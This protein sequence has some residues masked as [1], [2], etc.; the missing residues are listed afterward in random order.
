MPD[1][2]PLLT[3]SALN[4]AIVSLH[5]ITSSGDRLILDR[6]YDNIINNLRMSEINPDPE[7]TELYRE[8]VR[9]IQKGRLRDDIR[10]VIIK[11]DSEKKQKS[12]KEIITGNVLRSFSINPLKWLSKLAMSSASE[13][14]TQ[15]KE[16]QE[17]A[18]E[19]AQNNNE[20]QLRLKHDE[21][22]EYDELQRKLLISSWNLMSHY[23]LSDNY[24]LTQKALAKFSSV[25]NESDPSKRKTMMKYLEGDFSM[26]APYWFYRAKSASESGNDDEAGT[27]FERF[28]E[29]WRPALM[30]DSYQAEAMKY[31]IERLMRSGVNQDNAGEILKCLAVMRANT[32]LDDWAN[33]IFAGMIY[34]ALGMKDEAVDC[35]ICNVL[36]K[37]ENEM[38]SK[39][40]ERI[41]TE[42]FPQRIDLDDALRSAAKCGDR[43]VVEVLIKHGADVNAKSNYGFTALM[44]AAGRGHTEIVDALI[45]SGADVNAKDNDG[46]TA[47]MEAAN[48]KVAEL[49]IK[50]GAD[51]NA[52]ENDGETAL[53]WAYN[54]E[55]AE[56]LIKHGAD[57]NAKS[58]YGRT[59]LMI[60]TQEGHKEVAELLR[61]YGAK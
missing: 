5:R 26:Y 39:V 19:L 25:M 48:A 24:R 10:A 41:N 54:A 14:F 43:G 58:N 51:V 34:F 22:E 61:S 29:V 60:A 27:Y 46:W 7:L 13:Y 9:V 31:K 28:S 49:L 23:H 50:H 37:Y 8:I 3:M 4:M 12:I 40:L 2:D 1:Y 36:F 18:E 11:T 56:V 6:E 21:L 42:E 35:V 59:A 38:S 16:A 20:S 32:E 47:L 55:V 44:E 57:V 17:K 45:K 53:M 15:E 52:K 33:N 30:K